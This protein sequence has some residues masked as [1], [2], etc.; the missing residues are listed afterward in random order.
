M[1]NAC[2]LSGSQISGNKF[3]YNSVQIFECCAEDQILQDLIFRNKIMRYWFYLSTWLSR[4]FLPNQNGQVKMIFSLN[5]VESFISAWPK[6][7]GENDLYE[8]GT[9]SKGQIGGAGP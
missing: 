9:N 3:I 2:S 7:S 6:W 1:N 5:M 8:L 4:L